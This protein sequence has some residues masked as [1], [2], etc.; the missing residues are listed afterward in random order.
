M[1]TQS[2]HS[3]TLNPEQQEVFDLLVSGEDV[4]LSGNAGTGKS[5]VVNQFVNYLERLDKQVIICAF[6]GIAASNNLAYDEKSEDK[7]Y[8]EM[9]VLF[10]ATTSGI[11]CRRIYK[12]RD[13]TDFGPVL[14]TLPASNSFGVPFTNPGSLEFDKHTGE[15]I[16]VNKTSGSR[17]ASIWGIHVDVEFD[18]NK[19]VTYDE[20]GN[21]IYSIVA[22]FDE[23]RWKIDY[24]EDVELKQSLPS[25]ASRKAYIDKF[26]QPVH[27]I[28]DINKSLLICDSENNRVYKLNPSGKF[29]ITEVTD[30]FDI[31]DDASTYKQSYSMVTVTSAA[32]LQLTNFGRNFIQSKTREEIEATVTTT[33][34]RII[35]VKPRE[36]FMVK[37]LSS[38]TVIEAINNTGTALSV[39]DTVIV[40]RGMSGD[41][42]GVGT[43]IAKKALNDWTVETGK[44]Y[45]YTDA[46]STSLD[47]TKYGIAASSNSSSS[48]STSST[49][50]SAYN[51]RIQT[52]EGRVRTLAGLHGLSW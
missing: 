21:P 1:E 23:L 17:A 12:D 52:L 15:L 24:M 28:Y 51:S 34:G 13:R 29:Y 32:S 37:L 39:K 4:F 19:P 30:Q 14:A 20:D 5:Y 27:A 16:Y 45:T 7:E 10:T 8:R 50:L 35:E 42:S 26:F 22:E 11:R 38:D 43:I 36:K 49:D 2:T 47:I 18:P 44:P 48:G 33:M 25:D 6:T 9:G 46:T 40:M 31:S 41:S 3:S